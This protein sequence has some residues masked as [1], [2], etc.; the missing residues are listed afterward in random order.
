MRPPR[1]SIAALMALTAVVAVDCL[2]NRLAWHPWN[3]TGILFFFGGLPM[4]NILAIG[5]L[6][7]TRKMRR[8]ESATFLVGFEVVGWFLLLL[9]G[10]AAGV[11]ADEAVDI[12][13]RF[14]L[15]LMP[16]AGVAPPLGLAVAQGL[17][18]VML[19]VP[20]VIV[21]TA[22]GL[23]NRRYRIRI[24]RRAPGRVTQPIPGPEGRFPDRSQFSVN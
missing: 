22:G 21:A 2:L 13:G 3:A 17:V 16:L 8:G 14:T 10:W 19:T 12:L 20:L 23:V 1:F 11:V 15:P 4:F 7:L 24:E 6:F 9:S 5:L 18:M